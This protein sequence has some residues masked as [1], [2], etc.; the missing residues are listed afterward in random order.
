MKSY[1][2]GNDKKATSS[3]QLTLPP[4]HSNSSGLPHGSHSSTNEDNHPV[5]TDIPPASPLMWGELGSVDELLRNGQ[6]LLHCS[7]EQTS[8]KLPSNFWSVGKV[9]LT[10]ALCQLLEQELHW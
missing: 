8:L 3:A 4:T 1:L 7:S 6:V 5:M 10:E 2:S 9:A